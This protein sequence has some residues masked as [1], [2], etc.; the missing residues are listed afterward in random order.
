MNALK[1]FLASMSILVLSGCEKKEPAATH[2]G[3]V[4]KEKKTESKKKSKKVAQN[5]PWGEQFLLGEDYDAANELALLEDDLAL[6]SL[7]SENF[8]GDDSLAFNESESSVEDEIDALVALWENEED[9]LDVTLDPVHFDF[10][11]KTVSTSDKTTLKQNVETA[12]LAVEQGKN[13]TVEAYC[14]QTGPASYNLALSQKRA[15]TI[16]DE[17]VKSGVD[18]EHLAAIGRGQEN[19]IASSN[20]TDKAQM[21]KELAPNRRAEFLVS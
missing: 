2:K 20:S 10:N 1:L 21:I 6:D 16:V 13:I 18:S 4:S 12:K 3:K 8:F 11:K 5:D 14:D 19:Q 9:E 15:Q 17:M 7:T